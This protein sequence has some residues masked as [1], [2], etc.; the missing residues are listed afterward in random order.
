MN[1]TIEL[2]VDLA[3]EAE[4]SDPLDWN[5]LHINKQSAYHIMASQMI[6]LFGEPQTQREIVIMSSMLKLI[7]ENFLLNTR[8]LRQDSCE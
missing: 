4:I 5:N 1:D 2:L 6:E 8:L 7:V 3:Q